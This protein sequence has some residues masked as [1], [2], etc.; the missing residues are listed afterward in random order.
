[1]TCT[2]FGRDLTKMI[3]VKPSCKVPSA[4]NEPRLAGFGALTHVS[5]NSG[6]LL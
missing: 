3:H 2:I 5:D 6:F 4:A 1:M